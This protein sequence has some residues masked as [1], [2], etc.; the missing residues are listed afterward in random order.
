MALSKKQIKFLEGK[1]IAEKEE[2]EKQIK[3]LSIPPVFSSE[4]NRFQEEEKADEIEETG[5]RLSAGE[6]L[7]HDLSDIKNALQKMK[8]KNYGICEKCGE[9]ISFKVLKTEPASIF[10]QK[11]KREKND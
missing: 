6:V 11:C 4:K 3:E 5:N 9:L 10:C 7:R 2:L 1:L 8:K